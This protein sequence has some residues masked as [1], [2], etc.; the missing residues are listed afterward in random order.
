M[1]V[2]GLFFGGTIG[3]VVS[4]VMFGVKVYSLDLHH[5]AKLAKERIA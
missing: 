5:E 2:G 1:G 3:T 4:T